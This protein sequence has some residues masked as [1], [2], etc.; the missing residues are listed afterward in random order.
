MPSMDTGRFVR[1]GLGLAGV[2]SVVVVGLFATGFVM[3]AAGVGTPAEAG[4]KQPTTEAAGATEIA[5]PQGMNGPDS[6]AAG[7]GATGT[8]GQRPGAAKVTAGALAARRAFEQY[9]SD[10]I[11]SGKAAGGTGEGVSVAP[12]AADAVPADPAAVK[13][14]LDAMEQAG[15]F[16]GLTELL[17]RGSRGMSEGERAA[18]L[19][20]LEG[21]QNNGRMPV[22]FLMAR[23]HQ[24]AGNKDEAAKWFMAA[25]VVGRIDAG[26]C[27]DKTAM[28]HVAAM[29]SHFP[30]V[31]IL[32]KEDAAKAKRLARE[33]LE[34]EE[35]LKGREKPEWMAGNGGFLGDAAYGEKR[36]KMRG[37]LRESSVE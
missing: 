5:G 27:E 18:A 22:L 34:L 7:T 21:R 20:W 26:G 11:E 37:E 16:P 14:N 33:A 24:R 31:R 8:A 4:A 19:E 28:Q 17:L 15:E 25:S 12:N 30:D 32:L 1:V 6:G 9:A 36:T 13:V 29:E 3:H 23:L 10:T 2:G 35:K